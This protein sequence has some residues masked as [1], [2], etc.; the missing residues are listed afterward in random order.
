MASSV[1]QIGQSV[2][3][4]RIVERIGAGGMGVVYRAHD[5]Q[6]D[7]DVAIKVL[8]P[9]T[10]TATA[11]KRLHAEARTL[12]KLSH[13]N[14][15]HVY[16]FTSQNGADFLVMEYVDGMTLAKKLA[17]GPVAE[18]ELLALGE[19]IA[20]TLQYAH[21]HG[22]IHRDLKPGNIMVTSAGQV[23]LLDF[24]LAKMLRTSAT[25]ATESLSE[26]LGPAGTLSYMAPE[27][28][29]GTEPD[30]RS[31]I[32]SAG[33]VLYEMATTHKPFEDKISTALVGNILHKPPPPPQ[34]L[35]SSLS[36]KL[37][38]IILKC[39]EKDP[40]N[41]YQSAKELAIDLRRLASPSSVSGQIPIAQARIPRRPPVAIAVIAVGF[42]LALLL[43]LNSGQWW[44]RLIGKAATEQIK[45]LAVLPLENLSHDPT[46]DYF[47]D[48][49]TDEL[50]SDLAQIGSLRVISRTS[51]MHFKGTREPLREIARELNVDVVVEGSV[52]RVG[53]RVR[54]TAELADP[55]SDR[56]L[57]ANSYERDQHDVLALQREV[58]LAIAHQIKLTLTPQERQV[59]STAQPVNLK[60]Y[61]A[62]LQGRFYLSQRTPQ[63]L[64][65]GV[66]YFQRAIAED[67]K[68]AI[69]YAGLADSYG[70][71]T[72]YGVRPATETMPKAKA[73][74]LHAL[75]LDDNLAEAHASLAMIHWGFDWDMPGAE[76]EYRRALELAPG[77]ATAH[78]WY[79]LYLSSLGRHQEAIAEMQQAQ[80]LDP[81]SPI[82]STNIAWCRYLA[83]QYDQAIQ[84]ARVTLQQ[85]PDFAAAHEVLG[86]AYAE[87]SMAEEAIPELQ[88]VILI[89]GDAP[90][91][92]AELGYAYA[93]YGKRE[94]ALAI[95]AKLTDESHRNTVP[96]YAMAI[97]HVGLGNR[98]EAL[99]WLEKS[100][101]ERDVRLVNLKVHPMFDRVRSDP[102]FQ[103]LLRRIGLSY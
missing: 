102:R 44:Q 63:A 3:H 17:K 32:Y 30:F 38:D 81:L 20:R 21:E 61:E 1:P 24:G 70:L 76:K 75:E 88:K 58:A 10:L 36:P 50:I 16:Q 15:S 6:L 82:I 41:R 80:I 8:P 47:A 9:G 54:I 83:H 51:A 92:Q 4:Y 57:W 40:E 99:R 96:P 48:G 93:V 77:Y 37:Q 23:K 45:S 98:D 22:I 67:P 62:Y 66:E 90:L 59:L 86:Q 85:F 65:T 79:A 74:A 42:V 103:D 68:Y 2:G 72:S 27:Q 78:H 39:L 87:N 25:A 5:E 91:A 60:A 13:A 28:L 89:A 56:A 73:A 84:Q 71:L 14:I 94:E 49:M 11:R 43:A 100:Y 34:M 97:L 95:L 19:Q 18:E 53:D 29:R 69:A 12:A 55:R 7:R 101:Q 35:R 33:V 26:V 64:T 31:D 46:Q 52:L